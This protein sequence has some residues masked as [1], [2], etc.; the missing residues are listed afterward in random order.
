MSGKLRCFFLFVLVLTFNVTAWAQAP[1]SVTSTNPANGATNVMR[2]VFVSA[3]VFVPNGGIDPATLNSSTAFLYRTSDLQNVP[4]VLNTSG[5]GDVIVLRPVSLLDANTSYTFQVTNGLKD[6]TNV[7]FVPFT[8]SFTTGTGTGGTDTSVTFAKVA[9]PNAPVKTYTSVLLGPDG[10]LYAGTINGEILRFAINADGTLGAPQSIVSLQTANGGN[11]LLIGLKFDPSSTAGNLIL[12]ASHSA[13][14]FSNGPDWAGKITRLS[15]VDLETVVDYVVGLP[16]S[17]RDHVTNQ[18][19]FGPDGAMYFLQGSNSAMGAGDSAWNFRQERL[20]NAAVL[21]LDLAA[22][23]SPPLDV[24]TEEGG[25]YDPF[26]PG[27]PLTI[28]A[29]GVRNAFD[30]AWHRNGFLY[31]PTN[32]SASGGSTPAT[33][34]PFLPPYTPRL[35]ESANGPYTGPEV[36]ALSAVS[37]TMNDFLFRVVQGGYYG[38]PNPTRHEYVLN[39]GNPTAGSDPA[40]VDA[41][42]VGT[43]PDRN[44]RGAAF[45][46][47]QHYS[48]DGIIEYKSNVFGGALTGKLLV[49]RYSGG[50]DII[51]LTPGL[52]GDIINSQTGISGFTGF[53][54]PLDIIEN[55]ANGFLYLA[56]YGGQKLILLK[57]VLPTAPS[58]P[59][60]LTATTA[61]SSQI[62]L[63]WTD[64]ANNESGFRIERKLGAGGTYA[65]IATVGPNVT[66]YSDTGLAAS[67]TYYYQARAYNAIGNSAYSNQANATTSVVTPPANGTGLRGQYY[68]NTNFT[69]LRLTRTDATIN[70]TWSGSPATGVGGDTFSVRWT[71]QVQAR[72]SQLYRFYTQSDDGVRLWVN[73][74]QLVNNWTN[75]SST[76]NSGTI[77]LVANQKYDIVMEFYENTG[78]A[79]AKLSW[80]S[81]SQAKQI[82]PQSQLYPAVTAPAGPSNLT[83]NA[84]STS[85]INLAWTDNANNETGFRIER[86]LNGS[87]FTEIATVAANVTTFNNTGL[88]AAT[89]YSY[90]VRATN[91]GGNSAYSNTASATTQATSSTLYEAESAVLVGAVVSNI[92]T[93]YTGTG[94]VDYIN[95]SADYIQWTVS[96]PSTGSYTLD[97]RYGNGGATNRPLELRVNQALVNSSLPFASTGTWTNWSLS[98]APVSLNAGTNTIR[99]TAIGSS[100]ANID[101]L[102]VR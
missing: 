4:A 69:T 41:Y 102:T 29:S 88:A 87:S 98:S 79:V 85:Q 26:A 89:A 101:S 90:R 28:F 52:N 23:T 17:T 64:N 53:T 56:E 3:D 14:T 54:D 15:G 20:L 39:G 19:D 43:L 96:V 86:S 47:G 59:T 91:S 2:D 74:V 22:I 37:Q 42:P 5:G 51:V 25:T 34:S 7:G 68:D 67:T 55:P 57:P 63:A 72:F 30:L 93:G 71:G 78:S 94:F 18:I 77:T 33:P 62:N 13:F 76:E 97:F 46:F 45:D 50:D 10:K 84:V 49:V 60:G 40:Q 81:P 16:R 24:K 80:S 31:V 11:R 70:F 58:A 82:I 6:I 65:E 32:G 75:H 27:V 8:M 48:P 9:L 66:S 99:L 100:G 92:H 61:S 1:P 35:D 95:P 38:H 21:R 73:G 36:P 44:W 12:W 83:A